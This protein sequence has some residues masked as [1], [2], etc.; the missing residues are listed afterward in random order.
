M[1]PNEMTPELAVGDLVTK[2][3]ECGDQ[4][5]RH[6]SLPAGTDFTPLLKGLPDDLC[7]CPH[8]GYIIDGSITVRYADGTEDV[9]KAGD[10]YYWP[11]GHTGWSDNG[12]TFV[13]FSPAEE[14]RP[15]LAHVG[16][17][18]ATAG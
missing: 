10:I 7:H 18:L 5:V 17:Q 8:Y 11:A 6:L 12:V 4:I 1:T 9:N 3:D 14:L 13:E 16:A 2:G 15:V